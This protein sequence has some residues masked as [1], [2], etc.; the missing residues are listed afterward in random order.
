MLFRSN[1]FNLNIP[2]YVDSSEEEEAV[3][4]GETVDEISQI[5]GEIEKLNAD[6][7]TAILQL[8][9]DDAEDMADLGKLA[10]LFKGG[11]R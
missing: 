8:T 1:G 11:G 2:R 3:N 5:D 7:C 10:D 9:S 4:L 6:I